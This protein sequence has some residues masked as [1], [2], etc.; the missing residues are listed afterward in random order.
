MS[1]VRRKRGRAFASKRS[2]QA[3]AGQGRAQ[4]LAAG[5]LAEAGAVQQAV[6]SRIACESPSIAQF[7]QKKKKKKKKKKSS[8]AGA[9][10]AKIAAARPDQNPRPALC[11]AH[12]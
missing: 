6:R 9:M 5:Q 2:S 1:R 4:P 12:S 7:R 8:A 11:G 10:G 3:V